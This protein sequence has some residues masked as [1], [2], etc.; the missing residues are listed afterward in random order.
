MNN[1]KEIF[2]QQTPSLLMSEDLM[3]QLDL[4]DDEKQLLQTRSKI[5]VIKIKYDTKQDIIL[6]QLNS[7]GF[8]KTTKQFNIEVSAKQEC[9]IEF[10]DAYVKNVVSIHA[11]EIHRGDNILSLFD[12]SQTPYDCIKCNV[13]DTTI[14]NE[15]CTLLLTILK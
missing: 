8:D 11:I 10:I 2:S 12:E 6:G 5:V 3:G 7:L 15:E 1:S 13:Y 4:E 14:T 9:C